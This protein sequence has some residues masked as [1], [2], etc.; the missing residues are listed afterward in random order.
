MPLP[1]T[2]L[3]IRGGCNCSAVR[4]TIRIPELAK[5]PIHPLV[6]AHEPKIQGG[7]PRMCR[8]PFTTWDHCNDCRTATGAL[9][10]AW[11]CV[12][13][14][15]VSVTCLTIDAVP[16]ADDLIY[17][18]VNVTVP[19]G[20]FPRRQDEN[21]SGDG[22]TI[23]RPG[24]DLLSP[25]SFE[26]GS[27]DNPVSSTWLRFHKSSDPRYRSFCGRCGTP[28]CYNYRPMPDGWPEMLDIVLGTID[29]EDL[30]REVGEDDDAAG[31]DKLGRRRGIL[32]P[33]R[34]LWLE[35]GIPWLRRAVWDLHG[36]KSP[37]SSPAIQLSSLDSL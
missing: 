22:T 18:T 7:D 37:G 19:V 28:I 8:M 29:R 30:E 21:H 10:P 13:A 34:Q 3:T 11:I 17:P 20:K 12:P 16:P 26:H 14:E 24:L 33:E 36:P 31:T 9:L 6:A 2:P 32:E 23:T 15:M 35:P 25:V 5:R 27:I 1:D 4:Y